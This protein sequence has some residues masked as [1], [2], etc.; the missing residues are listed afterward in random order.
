MAPARRSTRASGPR[1]N[2]TDDPFEAAGIS[3]SDNGYSSSDPRPNK[4]GKR[5]KMVVTPEDGSSD[6]DF[7][8]DNNVDGGIGNDEDEEDKG[9]DEEEEEEDG[10]ISDGDRGI[11][12]G[13]RRLNM[14][15]KSKARNT[16]VTRL[17]RT[18]GWKLGTDPIERLRDDETRQRGV[19]STNE[20]S[21]K[22]D[23]MQVTFGTDY[24]DL[25]AIIYERDRWRKGVDSTFPTRSSLDEVED[26]PDYGVG[27]SFGVDPQL[28][29]IERTRGWD[30]Y[31]DANVGARLRQKQQFATIGEDAASRTY[32][33][34]PKKDAHT[35]IIGPARK[36]EVFKLRQN[37][38]VNFGQAW[39]E[40][41]HQ[42]GFESGETQ[43]KARE[44]WILNTGSKI[45]CLD[46]APNQRGLTQY[47]AVVAPIS[48][49]QKKSLANPEEVKTPT[50]SS[51]H[52]DPS[53]LQIWAFRA[54]QDGGMTKRLD[55]DFKPMLRLALCTDWGDLRRISWCPV[56]RD[57]REEDE[58]EGALAG[59]GL[60]AGVW[61]DG[62][63]RVLD[64]RIRDD[65]QT[66]E[67][68]KRGLFNMPKEKKKK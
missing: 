59:T 33:P 10:R 27:R 17:G 45:Q 21:A 51:S 43:R 13:T 30:W 5:R 39:P 36:Q 8:D 37:E 9:E 20:Y 3:D 26:I 2:Y 48:D 24:R 47:L 6:Q 42:G 7:V 35:V 46:W 28:M 16:V 18:W 60:I 53:A 61:A 19:W 44:G 25:L 23:N 32:L 64:V 52:Q 66:S 55:M 15:T 12:K 57:L 22:V 34:L 38:S 63:V 4:S 68:C 67:F 65:F 31:Y 50:F 49:E 40:L 1:A 62:C 54:R 29:K 41:E 11:R 14:G 58:Q 56:A